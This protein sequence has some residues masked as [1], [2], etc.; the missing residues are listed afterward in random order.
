LAYE[1]LT[2]GEIVEW[3]LEN[4]GERYRAVPRGSGWGLWAWLFPP[5]GLLAGGFLV[6]TALRRFRPEPRGSIHTT[7]SSS[8]PAPGITRD[9]EDRLRSAIREIEIGEDPSF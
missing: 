9:E 2:S 8:G 4:H 5:I 3:M 6:V 1:G 7:S